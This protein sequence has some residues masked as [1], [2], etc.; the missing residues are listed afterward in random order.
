MNHGIGSY[1]YAFFSIID[2][3]GEE[4]PNERANRGFT[5]NMGMQIVI[6]PSINCLREEVVTIFEF[7]K[8]KPIMLY[9]VV[10]K[11]M[12]KHTKLQIIF[13]HAFPILPNVVAV[14]A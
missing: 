6:M 4:V 10:K 9:L 1:S 8:P 11:E 12:T 3:V 13:I 14:V 5:I 2:F 7:S